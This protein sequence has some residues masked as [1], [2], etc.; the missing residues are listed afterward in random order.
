M[1]REFK[2]KKMAEVLNV[3]VGMNFSDAMS[4]L[5]GCR[6]SLGEL[7]TMSGEELKKAEAN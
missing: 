5:D 7:C 3:L 4:V 6:R 2:A 1:E